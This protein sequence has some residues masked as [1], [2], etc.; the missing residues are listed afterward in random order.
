MIST[1]FL[2]IDCA[3]VVLGWASE[4]IPHCRN[5][6][7]IQTREEGKEK[8]KKG[9]CNAEP[10]NKVKQDACEFA[11]TQSKTVHNIGLR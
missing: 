5:M 4:T 3:K 11:C 2:T 7:N 6:Q 1:E 10:M 9:H 8:S